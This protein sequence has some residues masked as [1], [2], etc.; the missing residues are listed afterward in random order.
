MIDYRI[1][2]D[3]K[4]TQRIGELASMMEHTRSITLAEVANLTQ[5]E[6]DYLEDESSNT[7]GGLLLHI[8]SIEFVHQV[9]SFEGRDINEQE[10][11]EWKSALTL[12]KNAIHEIKGHD[13]QFYLDK[14]SLV[15]EKTL[16]QF[17]RLNDEWLFEEN[18]WGN[19]VPYNN[20]YLWFHVMEDEINHRGQIRAIK[21]K[22]AQGI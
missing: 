5:A 14:L 16:I 18:Q 9:I 4:F 19:G 11:Q 13:I 17:K 1:K 12:G 15:R 20:Y 22:S 10:L 6:L 7:I 8:A 2:T 21:R 3:L